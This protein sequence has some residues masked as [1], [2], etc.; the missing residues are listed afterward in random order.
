MSTSASFRRSSYSH[1]G[2]DRSAFCHLRTRS[3]PK[4]RTNAAEGSF[5]REDRFHIL[6]SKKLASGKPSR[7]GPP[8]AADCGLGKRPNIG[9]RRSAKLHWRIDHTRFNGALISFRS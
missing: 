3:P 6:T 8:P 5:C 4:P 9:R 1:S 7:L 2:P